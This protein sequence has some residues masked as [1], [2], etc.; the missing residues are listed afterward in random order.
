MKFITGRYAVRAIFF[1]ISNID[2]SDFWS[3]IAPYLYSVR[4]PHSWIKLP[5]VN[6]QY[7]FPLLFID[8]KNS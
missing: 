2:E 3:G 1:D 5:A 8:I 7:G 6:T 4:N